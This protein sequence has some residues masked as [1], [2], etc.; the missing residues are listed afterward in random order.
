MPQ[1]T[2]SVLETWERKVTVEAD[3]VAEAVAMWEA[4]DVYEWE[5]PEYV[6][7]TPHSLEVYNERGVRVHPV[8]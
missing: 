1:Y 2:L 6:E 7:E 3:S 8:A 5:S 4:G